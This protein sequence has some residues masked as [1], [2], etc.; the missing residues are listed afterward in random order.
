LIVTHAD[1]RLP[2]GSFAET[3]MSRQALVLG[4]TGFLGGHL[5]ARLKREGF[6]IRAVGTRDPQHRSGGLDCDHFTKGDLRERDFVGAVFDRPFDEVYQLAADMGGAGYLFTGER[7]AAV[8]RNSALINLEV[9]EA[10]RT[11]QCRR[12]FFSSTA[13]VY[14]ARNQRD[15]DN[16]MCAEETAYPA[17]PDSEYGWEKLFSERAYMAYARNYGMT[18]RIGRYHTCYGPFCTWRGGRE[19]VIPAICRKVAEAA[20]GGEIEI[21][22]DGN[23]TRSFTYI[24]DAVEATLRLMR[25]NCSVPVNIGSEEMVTI[26]RLV[27]M[28]CEVAGKR[29]ARR[30]IDGPLGVRGRNSDNGLIRQMLNWE[31]SIPLR[32]GLAPTYRW[33]E[34]Q[35]R[36]SQAAN[37]S[38]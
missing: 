1:A 9:L 25:S 34:Q 37:H 8:I 35:V 18:V 31:P 32:A 33:I 26:N 3:G 13:C 23:Q 7:D 11:A 24:D 16:P 10:A 21:W 28:I 20:D 14:P 27:D 36:Q 30:H 12:L 19:K 6:W 38:T 17:E 4:G 22:G 2:R 5:C 15:P 29:L